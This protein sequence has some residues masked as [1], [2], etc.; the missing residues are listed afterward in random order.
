MC[1]RDRHGPVLLSLFNGKEFKN[2]DQAQNDCLEDLKFA[3][4][5]K[6]TKPF[7]LKWEGCYGKL[8]RGIYEVF[9][10]TFDFMSSQKDVN[11]QVTHVLFIV[12]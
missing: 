1:I 9:L 3:I 2:L 5:W 4:D 7:E 6:D 8:E 10:Q 12:H 11:P